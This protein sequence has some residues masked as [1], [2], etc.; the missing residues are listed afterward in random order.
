MAE[1]KQCGYALKSAGWLLV[2]P[3]L[4]V[5]LAACDAGRWPLGS[6]VPPQSVSH[7]PAASP[8]KGRATPVPV[9]SEKPGAV[10]TKSPAAQ[11]DVASVT[12]A[13]APAALPKV[14]GGDGDTP[15]V[16][17]D[18][19]Q[20]RGVLGPP[21]EEEQRAPAKIW[22]YRTAQCTLD[23]ALYPDVQTHVFRVLNYE[24]NG[25]DGTEQ[26]RRQCI[27]GLRSGARTR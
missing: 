9:T 17:L 4:L 8:A 18:M 21:T 1:T 27:A 26:G 23:V 14:P 22:R 24:V 10:A 7:H 20:A 19:E 15:L 12:P 13:L 3:C 2:Y 16:G 5:F 25:N 6:E 11:A